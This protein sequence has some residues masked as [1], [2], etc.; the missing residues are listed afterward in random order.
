MDELETQDQAEAFVK[1]LTAHQRDLYSY[2][3]TLLVGD[4]ATS[5]VLQDTNLDLWKRLKDFDF[6]RPFL[7]WAYAFAFQR[8]QAF[9]KSQV[10]SRLVFSDNV[11]QAISADYVSDPVGADT[12]LG[13]L[14]DCLEKLDRDQMQLIRE[15]YQGRVSVKALASRIGSSASQI[16][17]R[18]YRIRQ[19]LGKCVEAKLAS[20]AK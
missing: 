18:L 3:S 19:A 6:N 20:E 12:R 4:I 17:A 15:R 7:P 13:A 14:N 16:S 8:V 11:L 5:D 2:I 10:R 9:R 1:L